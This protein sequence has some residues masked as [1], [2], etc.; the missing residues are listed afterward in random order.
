MQIE[1]VVLKDLNN[2]IVKIIDKNP[3]LWYRIR[4]TGV[5]TISSIIQHNYRYDGKMIMITNAEKTYS[6]A[7]KITNYINI[8]ITN[9]W[10][11]FSLDGNPPRTHSKRYDLADP[12]SLDKAKGLL[13]KL[14]RRYICQ[15]PKP[16]K[17]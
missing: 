4:P 5:Q 1:E 3:E 9:D 7:V 10:P 14:I 17:S 13:S 16:I 2:H 6:I 12:R 15:S 11:P 8:T